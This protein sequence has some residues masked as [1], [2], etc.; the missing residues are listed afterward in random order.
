[1]VEPVT[2]LCASTCGAGPACCPAGT[3]CSGGSCAGAPGPTEPTGPDCGGD[4]CPLETECDG[5]TCCPPDHPIGCGSACCLPDASCSGGQCGCPGGTSLV[6]GTCVGPCPSAAPDHCGTLLCC[7]PSATCGADQQCHCGAD[8]PIECGELCCAGDQA[9]VN[10]A[11]HCA[12]DHPGDCGDTCCASDEICVM[13]A[14]QQAPPPAAFEQ[15]SGTWSGTWTPNCSGSSPFTRSGDVD[16]QVNN[17]TVNEISP[18]NG[19][20]AIAGNR[21]MFGDATQNNIVFMGTVDEAKGTASGAWS[22]HIPG[23]CFQAGD[24]GGSWSATRKFP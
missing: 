17:G 13:G 12:G 18:Q 23:T 11:C 15:W 24:G 5:G 2:S 22:Q 16:F 6:D 19:T 4:F 10:G 8:H 7:G 1:V 9:C 20:G 3:T 21:I 14:C